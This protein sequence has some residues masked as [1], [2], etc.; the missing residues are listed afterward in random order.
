MSE[1]TATKKSDIRYC[2]HGCGEVVRNNYK[3]GHDSKHVA[4]S[5]QDII[6]SDLPLSHA[7]ATH[8]ALMPTPAMHNKLVRALRKVDILWDPETCMFYRPTYI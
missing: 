4:N 8:V 7:A 1:N 3:T 2:L 5:V 6:Y